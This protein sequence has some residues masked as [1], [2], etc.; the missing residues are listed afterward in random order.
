MSKITTSTI[1]RETKTTR[2]VVSAA[3]PRNPREARHRLD[4]DVQAKL[5]RLRDR[6]P[7][8]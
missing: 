2:E 4:V 1:A 5:G 7:R 8:G 6:L 3:Y